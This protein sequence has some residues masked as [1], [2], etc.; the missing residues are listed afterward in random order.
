MTK[1]VFPGSFDPIT[2]GH[3]SI[4]ERASVLFSEVHV[5]IAEQP[6]TSK[7]PFWSIDQRQAFVEVSVAHLTNVKVH[8][9]CG[10]LV[11]FLQ[12]QNIPTIVRGL[13]SAVDWHYESELFQVYKILWPAVEMVC[14]RSD[15]QYDAVSS[16]NVREVLK[17]GG[18]IEKFVPKSILALLRQE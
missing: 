8:R 16:T 3:L 14:L 6:S 4:I 1:V 17:Y 18:D 2:L 10:L 11:D 12:Q 13:R 15:H 9:F 5:A 7:F